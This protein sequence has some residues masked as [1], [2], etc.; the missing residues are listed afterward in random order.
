MA[1]TRPSGRR[2]PAHCAPWFSF[3]LIVGYVVRD[4]SRAWGTVDTIERLTDAFDQ[5]VQSDPSAPRVHV[6]DLSLQ[7]G[8]PMRG[9]ISHQSGRDADITTISEPVKA[10]VSAGR[11]P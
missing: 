6:H 4:P 10:S 2:T 3:L 7:N 9:H 5:V 1:C 8:G 11:W